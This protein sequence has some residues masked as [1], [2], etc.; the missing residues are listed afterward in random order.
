M[1]EAVRKEACDNAVRYIHEVAEEAWKGSYTECDEEKLTYVEG[2]I[3]ALQN[4]NAAL[5]VQE[6]NDPLTW[7]QIAERVGKPVCDCH[8]NDYRIVAWVDTESK[9]II[10]TDGTTIGH[11]DG[12]TAFYAREPTHAPEK[13]C[14]A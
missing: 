6:Q 2:L 14:G 1:S 4:E 11:Q 9:T 10:F 5:R 7:D 3:R 12:V 8:G 13:G